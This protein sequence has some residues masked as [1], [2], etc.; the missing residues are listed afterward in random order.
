[1]NNKLNSYKSCT[2]SDH[3]AG[4]VCLFSLVSIINDCTKAEAY[5]PEV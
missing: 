4:Q 2:D 1:M 5:N 3:F